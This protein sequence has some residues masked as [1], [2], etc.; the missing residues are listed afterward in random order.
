MRAQS[1]WLKDRIYEKVDGISILKCMTMLKLLN[2][3]KNDR[4][5]MNTVENE[6]SIK[7]TCVRSHSEHREKQRY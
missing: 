3:S 5:R 7:Q 4:T 1:Q 6:I 2:K